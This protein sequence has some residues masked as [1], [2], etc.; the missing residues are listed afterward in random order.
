MRVLT[1]GRGLSAR[2]FVSVGCF[3][4]GGQPTAPTHFDV[5]SGVFAGF[6][7]TEGEVVILREES[8]V[9]YPRAFH[10]DDCY[11]CSGAHGA[12]GFGRPSRLGIF[13]QCLPGLQDEARVGLFQLLKGGVAREDERSTQNAGALD[14]R[15]GADVARRRMASG[16]QADDPH[17]SD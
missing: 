10:A 8:T 14:V 1:D 7:A 15:L 11:A 13:V 16:G 2:L 5:F 3:T 6:N 4:A 17:Q 9:V 12:D